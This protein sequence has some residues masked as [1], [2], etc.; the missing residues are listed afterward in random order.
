MKT[1]LPKNAESQRGWVELDAQGKTLGRVSTLAATILCGK[2]K[3]IYTPHIDTG[4]FVIVVN[5][6]GIKL[7][8]EKVR[9]KA[10]IRPST[11]PGKLKS[12]SYGDLLK[13]NPR[14]LVEIAVK[15][16]LPKNRM[17]RRLFTKLKVYAE[18]AHP[19]AA[20]QPRKIEVK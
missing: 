1:T 17:G 6:A 11:M 20:Q 2:N 3:P 16:M 15:R 19:H 13:K 10:A 8:G 7:T 4:D 12:T 9:D 5:A 18:E 14:R